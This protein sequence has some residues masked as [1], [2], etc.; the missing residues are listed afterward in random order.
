MDRRAFVTAAALGAGAATLPLPAASQNAV[1]GAP[2]PLRRPRPSAADGGVSATIA[3]HVATAR[4]AD[5]DATT[6]RNAKL[7]LIDLIGCAI[8][9]MRGEGGAALAGVM[10]GGGGQGGSASV[11]GTGQR[12]AA[13]DAAMANAVLA[14]TFDFEVMTVVVDGLQVP[15]HHAPTTVMTALA[16]AEQHRVDGAAFLT[17]LAI[18]DD[19]AARTLA[20]SG[21]DFNDGWDGAPLHSTMAAAAIAA[22]VAGLDAVRTRHAIALA[23]DTIHGTVQSIWDGGNA[24]KVQQGAAARNGILAAELAAAGWSGMADP[25]MA[26]C[27]FYGQFTPG[28]ARPELLT[29]RLGRDWHGEIYFKPWPSCAANHPTIECALALRD[30]EQLAPGDIA[31]VRLMVA[32]HI[33]NLFI[34]KPLE[35]G[36]SAHSQANFNIY[37]ACAT[38]LLHGDLRQEHYTPAALRQ[39]ALRS[40]IAR[41]TLAPLPPGARGVVLEVR[42][43]NGQV[44]TEA[45]PGKPRRYPDVAGSTRAEV[46]AKF[47]QQVAF[48]G[49]I[50]AAKANAIIDRIDRV[51]RERDMADFARLLA[52]TI[53][54]PRT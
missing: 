23:T 42:R 18:G 41:M 14:R 5:L 9:G 13:R 32:P 25:L 4:F 40:L 50:A 7:R 11:F 29:R 45:L 31:S 30:R 20:A 36:P 17:A 46:E 2:R 21:I 54:F 22:R 38:A 6:I 48:A 52:D 33:L 44:I 43:T 15:S 53:R 24:W 27:G 19:L 10:A 1:N 35:P 16:L 37:F 51:E 26:P 39:P 28:A 8:G 49:N 3:A 12:A 47:H 34:A